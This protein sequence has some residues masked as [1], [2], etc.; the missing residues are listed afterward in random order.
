MGSR[1]PLRG[2]PSSSPASATSSPVCQAVA[3]TWHGTTWAA[4]GLRRESFSPAPSPSPASRPLPSS[5]DT[6]LTRSA[7]RISAPGALGGDDS[8]LHLPSPPLPPPPWPVPWYY[9]TER[10]PTHPPTLPCNRQQ[11][12]GNRQH[13]K[14]ELPSGCVRVKATRLGDRVPCAAPHAVLARSRYYYYCLL[15]NE[16]SRLRG[17]Y[18][19][20]AHMR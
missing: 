9:C 12:T 16:C 20:C 6:R 11:A 13:P 10:N 3:A 15:A 17:D 7:S 2:L 5:R 19:P 14:P 4:S 1:Q 18:G 8:P